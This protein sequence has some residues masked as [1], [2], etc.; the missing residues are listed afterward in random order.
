MSNKARIQ[1]LQQKFE[2][3]TS[4]EEKLN[5]SGEIHRLK[6]QDEGIIL[7]SGEVECFGCG[8]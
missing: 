5:L 6:L 7:E 3:T 4:F 2:S 8:S 1:E